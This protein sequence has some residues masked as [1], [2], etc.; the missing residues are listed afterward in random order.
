[1]SLGGGLLQQ[2]TSSLYQVSGDDTSSEEEDLFDDAVGIALNPSSSSSE[3]DES[4]TGSAGGWSEEEGDS[5]SGSSASSAD[6]AILD[7]VEKSDSSSGSDSSNESSTVVTIQDIHPAKKKAPQS[8]V[9][10]TFDDIDEKR[11]K[12]SVAAAAAMFNDKTKAKGK[13][14]KDDD[15]KPKGKKGKKR[16]DSD[17]DSDESA[18]ERKSFRKKKDETKAVDEKKSSAKSNKDEKKA[19]AVDEKKKSIVKLKKDDTEATKKNE[20]SK[21][22]DEK[23]D[24]AG[25][26]KHGDKKDKQK[27][28]KDKKKKDGVADKVKKEEKAD[29]STKK[30]HGDKKDKHNK[31]TK[32]KKEKDGVVDGK[33]EVFPTSASN[34]GKEK[35]ELMGS[36]SG[37][38]GSFR[39][40]KSRDA[41]DEEIVGEGETPS[42]DDPTKKKRSG[43]FGSFRRNKSRDATEENLVETDEKGGDAPVTDEPAMEKDGS[44]FRS[45]HRKESQDA[46]EED[47]ENPGIGMNPDHTTG[48]MSGSRQLKESIHEKK[49]RFSS[50]RF[51]KKTPTE[52]NVIDDF[53]IEEEASDDDG[54]KENKQQSKPSFFMAPFRRRNK[55]APKDS[56]HSMHSFAE[57][58][59]PSL[60]SLDIPRDGVTWRNLAVA[61]LLLL[62]VLVLSNIGT[63]Y[64]GAKLALEKDDKFP[65]AVND[66][67]LMD[68]VTAGPCA[69]EDVFLEFKIKFDDR[70]DENGVILR[71]KGPAKTMLWNFDTGSFSSFTQ[72]QRENTFSICISPS[73][74]YEFQTTDLS[75]DGLV[76][77]FVDTIIYGT[78]Q[79][80]YNDELV[81]R[82]NGDC[83]TTDVTHCGAY[84][85]CTYNLTAG[86]SSGGCKTNCTSTS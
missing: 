4:A 6:R 3:D 52:V 38:F 31:S 39:R 20:K 40:K 64:L 81:A 47:E 86:G 8:V 2:K 63:A 21:G 83:N 75:G 43:M 41:A 5:S 51:K 77:L 19:K 69:F 18:G 33:Q 13:E 57:E 46:M 65:P 16:F 23:A 32:G 45:L 58:G 30:E 71:D 66:T 54:A 49:S 84:C 10:G 61:L 82:Y 78:W 29:A 44:M 25:K 9:K 56:L 62:V 76:G 73:L 85:S 59:D 42:T 36:K 80:S 68:N 7:A 24:A 14:M 22:E 50:L 67:V 26:K 15:T 79:L 34:L 60:Q 27:S 17:S 55:S 1:M 53:P 70:P 72:F 11:P 35:T 37:M 28:T 74:P 48:G 12:G